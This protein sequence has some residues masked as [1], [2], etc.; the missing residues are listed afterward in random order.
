MR[1]IARVDHDFGAH[2]TRNHAAAVNIADQR[3]RY[4]GRARKSH[5]GEVVR[6]QIY[7]RCA[8]GALDEHDVRLS[9]EVAIAV[10]HEPRQIRLHALISGGLCDPVNAALHHHLCA[11]LALWLEQYGIHVHAGRRAGG[12]RL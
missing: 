1:S 6:A 11:D 10:E 12:T 7:F 9:F 8:A 5:V 3:N 4:I 2:K